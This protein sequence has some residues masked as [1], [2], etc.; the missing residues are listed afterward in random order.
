MFE[1]AAFTLC[2]SAAAPP[3][4]QCGPALFFAGTQDGSLRRP[5]APGSPDVSQHPAIARFAGR[6]SCFFF[7]LVCL[8]EAL[9]SRLL[10]CLGSIDCIPLQN[11]W[12]FTASFTK[13]A[14]RRVQL[15]AI[16]PCACMHMLSLRARQSQ[17]TTQDETPRYDAID[18]TPGQCR[19]PRTHRY[20]ARVKTSVA[21]DGAPRVVAAPQR[22]ERHEGC[23]GARARRRRRAESRK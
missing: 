13:L 1:T 7:V 15:D 22:P 19:T 21:H 18:A 17:R 6:N 4:L 20:H 9:S 11:H 16:D 12:F 2:S 23:C 5:L 3:N 10:F 14:Q 8:C